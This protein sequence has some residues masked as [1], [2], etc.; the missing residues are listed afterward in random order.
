MKKNG[1]SQPY[2]TDATSRH[3][4][5]SVRSFAADLWQ[6]YLG[7]GSREYEDVR[8]FFRRTCITEGL[9]RPLVGALK[10]LSSGGGDPGNRASRSSSGEA[11]LDLL[12]ALDEHRSW[13]SAGRA[14]PTDS[15]ASWIP[16]IAELA[17]GSRGHRRHRSV[18]KHSAE[19]E[20]RLVDHEGVVSR[21]KDIE[22]LAR[23]WRIKELAVFGS[24]LREDFSRRSDVYL[25]VVFED[26]AH[27][28][29]FDL[30]DLQAE[31]EQLLGRP[32]DLVEKAGL[33][34]PYRRAK[35]LRIAKTIYAA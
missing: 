30:V 33:T 4:R 19:G 29:L 28:S 35:I 24:A 7:E 20:N 25:L 6:V 13:Q 16:A 9:G 11:R 27:L 18:D 22:P 12:L 21:L 34:N 15:T 10:W 14:S 31:L 23:R 32:V 1:G 17:A 2:A 5:S 26:G 3:S 8:E